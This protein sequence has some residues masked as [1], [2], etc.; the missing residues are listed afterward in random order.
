MISPYLILLFLD[1]A[2]IATGLFL[3]GKHEPGQSSYSFR[4]T[5]FCWLPIA[6]MGQPLHFLLML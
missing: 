3:A 6:T 1:Q 5:A 2:R 4:A